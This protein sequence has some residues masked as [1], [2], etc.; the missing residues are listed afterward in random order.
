MCYGPRLSFYG[1]AIPAFMPFLG[2]LDG[3]S[4]I[5]ATSGYSICVCLGHSLG[6][7]TD[8]SVP[9]NHAFGVLA[10]LHCEQVLNNDIPNGNFRKCL[11]S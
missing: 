4:F 9:G 11:C 10:D 7:V 1:A 6:P 8:D 5:G 3:L 2:L